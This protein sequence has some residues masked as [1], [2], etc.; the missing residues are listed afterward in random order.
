MANVSGSGGT[1]E[2]HSH[3]RAASYERCIPSA[4]EPLSAGDGSRQSPEM[5]FKLHITDTID[6]NN[7]NV[8]LDCKPLEWFKRANQPFLSFIWLSNGQEPR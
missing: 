7:L 4:A 5:V 8:V 6:C 1:G 2:T 3:R